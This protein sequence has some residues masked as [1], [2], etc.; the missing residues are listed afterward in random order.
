MRTFCSCGKGR[1]SAVYS[2]QDYS[3]KANNVTSGDYEVYYKGTTGSARQNLFGLPDNGTIQLVPYEDK[4]HLTHSINLV[5][6]FAKTALMSIGFGIF[7]IFT[8]RWWIGPVFFIWLC[9]ANWVIAIIRHGFFTT[10]L[11]DDI[12]KT[13]NCL[14]PPDP[15]PDKMNGRIKHWM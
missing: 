15:E 7:G 9:G 11:A 10:E 2:K 8:H 6:L 4:L 13:M 12:N 5:G 3:K 1:Y 14:P